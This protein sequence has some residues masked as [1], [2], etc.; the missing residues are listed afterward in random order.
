MS[1]KYGCL[2]A[3]SNTGLYNEYPDLGTTDRK[4]GK[5]MMRKAGEN[6]VT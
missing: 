1:I 3:S 5:S 2:I 4:E 6:P